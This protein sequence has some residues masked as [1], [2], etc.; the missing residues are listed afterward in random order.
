VQK[1]AQPTDGAF[2]DFQAA[3]AFHNPSYL[4][5]T[6]TVYDHLKQRQKKGLFEPGQKLQLLGVQASATQLGNPDRNAPDSGRHPPAAVP[7]PITFPVRRPLVP[8]RLQNFFRLRFQRMLDEVLDHRLKA[9]QITLQQGLDIFA[10]KIYR[11][12]CHRDHSFGLCFLS[13]YTVT[14]V[15]V[16]FCLSTDR[17]LFQT[18]FLQQFRDLISA[19][20]A[21]VLFSFSPF[22][23]FCFAFFL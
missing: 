2:G 9:G 17:R 15:P 1:T 8:F 23:N 19:V 7:V 20:M 5:G 10:V 4:P 18:T 3:K 13:D 11:H 21:N 6:D 22:N 12:F 14:E 16:V